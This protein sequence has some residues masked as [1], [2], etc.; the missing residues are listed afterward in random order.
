MDLHKL[1]VGCLLTAMA[2]SNSSTAGSAEEKVSTVDGYVLD[3]ACAFVRNVKKPLR[4][5]QCARACAEAGSPLI[6]L[7]E[8]GTIYWPIS[9]AMPAAGQNARLM[10]FA[11]KR[12]RAQGRLFERG[13]SH[14]LVIAKIEVVPAKE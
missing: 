4:G 14:A 10:E 7:A 3:S 9:D 11:G 2:L 6:I 5:G 13:G 12:V 8:D 1:L